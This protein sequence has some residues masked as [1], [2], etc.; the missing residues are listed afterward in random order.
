MAVIVTVGNQ[1]GGVGKTTTAHALATGLYF[2]GYKVLAVDMDPQANLSLTY[3]VNFNKP[4]IYEALKGEKKI[5]KI[6]QETYQGEI[7][8]S[9]INLAMLE[10]EL[11]GVMGREYYLRDLLESIKDNYDFIVLDTPP[12]LSVLTLNA[13][14]TTDDLII[15]VG[16]D[17]FSLQGLGQLYSTIEKVR[18][19]SNKNLNVAGLLITRHG[20]SNLSNDFKELIGEKALQLNTS[21]FNTVIREGVAIKEAQAEQSDIYSN[22]P[23]SNPT[24]DYL[25]FLG[26]YLEMKGANEDGEERL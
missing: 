10:L 17:I 8:P 12:T 5:D 2:K 26:E 24:K 19:Y 6:I 7:I 4:G 1:K 9:S 14:T 20:R 16:A 18:K 22:A 25:N 3:G 21:L 13:F 11:T 23:R 15:P